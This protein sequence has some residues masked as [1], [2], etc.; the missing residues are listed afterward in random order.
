MEAVQL[1]EPYLWID[2]G[3]YWGPLEKQEQDDVFILSVA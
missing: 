2:L 1:P 3:F